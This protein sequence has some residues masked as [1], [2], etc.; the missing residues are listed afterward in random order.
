VQLSSEQWQTYQ[1]SKKA[2][3]A[4]ED[5]RKAKKELSEVKK[6]EELPALKVDQVPSG[7]PIR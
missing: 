2:K 7:S 5:K 4:G 1:D 6:E 3:T